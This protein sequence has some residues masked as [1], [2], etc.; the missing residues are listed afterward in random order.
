MAARGTGSQ[1]IP[2]QGEC[3]LSDA[4]A[5]RLHCLTLAHSAAC[6][7]PTPQAGCCGIWGLAIA[8]CSAPAPARVTPGWGSRSLQVAR[9]RLHV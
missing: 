1:S 3:Q 7:S 9:M 8:C 2:A 5:V 4:S 6:R